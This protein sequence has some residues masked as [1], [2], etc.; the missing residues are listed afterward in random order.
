MEKVE[1]ILGNNTFIKKIILKLK[2]QNITI[3]EID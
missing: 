2:K 1:K 3:S